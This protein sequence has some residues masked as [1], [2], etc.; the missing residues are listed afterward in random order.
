MTPKLELSLLKSLRDLEIAYAQEMQ[1]N[2][3]TQE[4]EKIKI[5]TEIIKE[6]IK[7]E[8]SNNTTGSAR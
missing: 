5:L 2:G 4:A 1:T 3:Y 6:Q 7:N 8:N